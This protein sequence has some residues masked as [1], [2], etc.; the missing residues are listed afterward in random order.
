MKSLIKL[1]TMLIVHTYCHIMPSVQL[2][3]QISK[4]TFCE[5]NLAKVV[6]IHHFHV[7]IKQS[8]NDT[9][10]GTDAAIVDKN[11]YAAMETD[12]LLHLTCYGL[13]VSEVKGQHHWFVNFCFLQRKWV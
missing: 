12:G 10:T 11:V 3:T 5:S 1:S 8:I 7:Y 2:H 13:K 6:D 4:H 9:A